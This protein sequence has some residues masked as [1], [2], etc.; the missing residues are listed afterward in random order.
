MKD[1]KKLFGASAEELVQIVKELEADR[2]EKQRRLQ[3]A[4]ARLNRARGKVR[5][6]QEILKRLRARVVELT[7]SGNG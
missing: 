1:Y 7:P 4:V 2:N 5:S 6:Q 3:I